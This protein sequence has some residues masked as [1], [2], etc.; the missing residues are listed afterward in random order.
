MKKIAILI[1]LLAAFGIACAQPIWQRDAVVREGQN[2]Q[3]E[4]TV[5]RD[6][7]GNVI[8]F[9][10]T[11]LRGENCLM[12]AKYSPTGTALWQEPLI[13][14]DGTDL[15]S[16]IKAVLC[17]DGGIVL[18]WIEENNAFGYQLRL[19][20][21]SAS[22]NIL[23]NED[24]ILVCQCYGN[25]PQYLMTPDQDGGAYLFANHHPSAS[26]PAV[27]YAYRFSSAGVDVW[28][29]EHPFVSQDG[30][31]DIEA[32]AAPLSGDGFVVAY[33]QILSYYQGRVFRHF[34]SAGVSD[35]DISE[36]GTS[37]DDNAIQLLGRSA[38]KVSVL[39]KS[40]P[41]ST[42]ISIRTIDIATGT[43]IASE[44][45]II[46]HNPIP[47]SSNCGFRITNMQ[48]NGGI[49]LIAWYVLNEV[50][51][52]DQLFLSNQMQLLQTQ[53]IYSTTGRINSL[54]AGYDGSLRTFCVW[55]ELEN[56]TK[57]L[58]AQA[59]EHSS[60]N[61]L[62]PTQGI[63]ISTDLRGLSYYGMSAANGILQSWFAEDGGQADYLKHRAFDNT[64]TSLLT[65]EQETVTSV[66]NGYAWPLRTM[67]I[68]G[69]AVTIYQDTRSSDSRLYY[70][71]HD[72]NGDA[73]FLSEG[74]LIVSGNISNAYFF[75]AIPCG[76]N[77]FAVLFRNNG[78][79]LQVYG[80]DGTAQYTGMGLQISSTQVA[81]AR[82]ALCDGDI[83]IC[84]SE[85]GSSTG[86]K[87]SG[88]KISANQLAWGPSGIIIADN[89]V[90][91]RDL[92][93]PVGRYFMW[94]NRYSSTSI[95]EVVAKRVDANGN[96]LAGW[97]AE[98]NIVFQVTASD[99]VNPDYAA[100]HGDD[101]LM[102]VG[103]VASY[104]VYAQRVNSNA[105][106]PWGLDGVLISEPPHLVFG[107]YVDARGIV[108]GYRRNS[109]SISGMYLQCVR[110][111]GSMMYP[112][113]GF[114]LDGGNLNNAANIAFGRY[115]NGAL[116][117]VWS[118]GY[119]AGSDF[120]D[121]WYRSFNAAGQPQETIPQVLCGA[122]YDQKVPKISEP[123]SG[124]L[125][126]SWADSRAGWMG[127]S[128]SFYGVYLQKLAYGG[129]PNP[130]E[131]Q[132][133]SA[134]QLKS[135]YPNPFSSSVSINWTQK[136]SQ[137]AQCDIYNIRG[138]LVKRFTPSEAKAGEHSV[139]WEGEDTQ[140]RKVSPG[141]YIIKV[142]SGNHACSAKILRW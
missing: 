47:V 89:E 27:A 80:L 133:P 97:A 35:W 138:Q 22:G 105:E 51:H 59:I 103:Y 67:D 42:G 104:N 79:Y 49:S 33:L 61:L 94:S 72:A 82:M 57:I 29:P 65:P 14:K 119:D 1:A 54:E 137:P 141:V 63:T 40:L 37:A 86:N 76:N 62:Y 10:A 107:A 7:S 81:R 5:V 111:D 125:Y 139:L 73:M 95:S 113:P 24:S 64:G 48:D 18:S 8:N 115:S 140:G 58:K 98:G 12:A 85:A 38:Q 39:R 74:I 17:T 128:Q 114:L 26:A 44:A 106:L 69:N 19:Q 131:P 91:F 108:I 110:P 135:C 127:V 130:D 129:S 52:I 116:L 88:Q 68:A 3:Y 132:V 93:A 99:M 142:H 78:L 112:A 96:T 16:A 92:G 55:E 36:S 75:D 121:L 123:S 13:V 109:D 2:L 20:K 41:S 46:V 43:W 32:I 53:P 6:A 134:L 21:L 71:Q 70:Q 9:W 126:V 122:P 87:I 50:N 25:P 101:L 124:A 136:D 23:W 30:Y 60:G 11:Q 15:K 90:Y 4:G 77:R 45:S 31:L 34:T 56:Y 102:F 66:L 84:W 117:A 100:L 83:Y 120:T 118:A 28:G